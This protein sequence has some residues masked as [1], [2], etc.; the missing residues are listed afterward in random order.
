[1]AKI[2]DK[3]DDFVFDIVKQNICRYIDYFL[4][5]VPFY[6]NCLY[7]AARSKF[8]NFWYMKLQLQVNVIQNLV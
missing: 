4:G 5:A 7:L 6:L 2:N 3:L 1:M 8:V